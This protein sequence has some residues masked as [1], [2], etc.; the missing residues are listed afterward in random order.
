MSVHAGFP[1]QCGALECRQ[2]FRSGRRAGSRRQVIAACTSS[3]S[4]YRGLP[5]CQRN[6]RRA[7]GCRCRSPSNQVTLQSHLFVVGD[8]SL[9]QRRLVA[10]TVYTEQLLSLV[11]QNSAALGKPESHPMIVTRP[12]RINAC[13]DRISQLGCER[14]RRCAG[15]GDA[16]GDAGRFWWHA[17]IA[18]AG[19][20]LLAAS[21]W[22]RLLQ[23]RI[24]IAT[25]AN[26]LLRF[27][28]CISRTP[29]CC[30]DTLYAGRYPL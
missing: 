17:A 16:A 12:R 5:Q 21:E 22:A 3:E 18:T 23:Q 1:A 6:S 28:C 29:R 10:A 24:E 11:E 8:G 25:P 2:R 30:L 14:S 4:Q 19:R 20:L 13:G 7:A 9:P 27:R 15:A 26:S